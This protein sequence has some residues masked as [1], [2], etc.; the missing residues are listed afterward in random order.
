MTLRPYSA[1]VLASG[2]VILMILGF[3]FIF[4]R[5]PLLPEDLR[6]MGTSSA[7]MLAT[8][9]R[10]LNWLQRVFWVMGGYIFSAGALTAY[11]AL[12]SFRMRARGAAGVVMLAGLT[13]IG[14]MVIVNFIISSD[15][16][17]VLL[18][19]FLLWPLALVLYNIE[20]P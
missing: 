5:P 3:Y 9:P 1:T 10:L 8:V 6:F 7:Q 12:T 16:R 18:S 15:F 14:W 17:W 19:L 2:G 13:S 11:V 4:L 20:R